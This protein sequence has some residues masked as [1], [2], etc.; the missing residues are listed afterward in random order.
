MT[1]QLKN[2]LK[3]IALGTFVGFAFAF[4]GY[5]FTRGDQTQFGVVMFVLVPFISGFAVAAIVRHPKRV[6]ACCLCGL[7]LTVFMILL[8]GLEGY[9]C[10]IMASPLVVVGMTVGAIAG[11]FIRGR[12]IDK[13]D[14]SG[15]IT[16]VLLIVCPLFLAAADR[17]E[18]PFRAR[19]Q[20]ETFITSTTVSAS[21]ERTWDLIAEMQKLDGPRPY[22]LRVGLP[23]PQRCV[24][25]AAS[26]GGRRICYFNSGLIAQEVTDW[27][28]PVFMGLKVTE[29]TLPGRH[30]LSFI[31]ASYELSAQDTQTKVVRHTTI[32]TRLYPRWYW[33]PFERWGVTSEHDYV[34]SNLRR[35]TATKPSPQGISVNNRNF[36]STQPNS[37]HPERKAR[38]VGPLAPAG[39]TSL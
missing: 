28:R 8:A 1:S 6:M 18:R 29:N 12:F 36:P 7:S 20:Y 9:L 24:L 35:W 39:A 34:F 19:Q 15:K 27:R 37:P 21:P 31:D 3:G 2:L 23:V 26:V 30:W 22:L 33:R 14:Q 5:L 13:I 17:V 10:C 16:L 38:A 32:D 11:Y 25:E 4:G